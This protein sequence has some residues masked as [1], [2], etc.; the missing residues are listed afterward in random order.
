MVYA[1]PGVVITAVTFPGIIVH[2]LSHQIACRICKVPVFEVKYYQSK[3]PAGYVVHEVPSNPWKSLFIS[4]GPFIF[5][6]ILG[7]IITL[8]AYSIIDGFYTMDT[9]IGALLFLMKIV[10]YWLGI[11]IM[12]HAFPS[13]GDAKSMTKSI[14]QNKE[15]NIFARIVSA[16]LIGLCYIGAIGSIAWLDLFY[17]IGMSAILP[18]VLTMFIN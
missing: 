17:A 7:M 2:E 10:L 6:T 18:N 16:P 4:V 12:M 8:P 11:S 14:L 1:I 9:S 5:N 15:V 3:N 13:T